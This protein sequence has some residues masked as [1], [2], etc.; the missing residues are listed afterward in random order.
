MAPPMEEPRPDSAGEGGDGG[1][2]LRALAA[3]IERCEIR[4]DN[5]D[6]RYDRLIERLK[7]LARFTDGEMSQLELAD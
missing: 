6:A 4:Q 7:R 5:A 1:I 3:R 2:D